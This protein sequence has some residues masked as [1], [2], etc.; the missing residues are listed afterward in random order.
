VGL[1]LVTDLYELTMAASYLRRDMT[2]PATF[3]LFARGLPATRGF[4]VAAG[5][6][7][8]LRLLTEFSFDDGDL[9]W[10]AG[11]GFDD[12]TSVPSPRCASRATHGRFPKVE[13]CFPT[14]RSSRSPRPCRKRSWSRRS[15]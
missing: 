15:C 12:T 3:S 6:D 13:S 7:D 14:N 2:E 10:L 1:G 11:Q 9:A 8:V 5:L 4:L